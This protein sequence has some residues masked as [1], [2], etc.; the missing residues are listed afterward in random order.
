MKAKTTLLIAALLAAAPVLT[1]SATAWYKV[2]D[3]LTKIGSV[4]ITYIDMTRFE[5]IKALRGFWIKYEFSHTDEAWMVNYSMSCATRTMVKV[6][7]VVYNRNG[8][9]VK[10]DGQ[11]SDQTE[12]QLEAEERIMD[13]VCQDYAPPRPPQPPILKNI[14]GRF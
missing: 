2:G 3:G 4:Y 9:L 6:A 1:Q 14:P 8:R 5:K 13:F 12:V 7:E 10:F 11:R